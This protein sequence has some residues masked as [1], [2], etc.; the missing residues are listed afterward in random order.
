MSLLLA[1]YWYGCALGYNCEF[2]RSAKYFQRGIDINVAAKNLWGI[3]IM[4]SQLAF[5]DYFL[6]GKID[7]GF[8]IT[9]EAVSV[10]EESGD[11]Y[12]KTVAFVDHAFS[13][14]GKRLLKDVE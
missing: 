10:A 11:I 14:Y 12:C 6:A 7:L 3:A 9:Q 1:S 4:K 5:F 13:C 2:E 8:Q